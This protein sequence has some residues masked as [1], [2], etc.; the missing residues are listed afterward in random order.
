M[1]DNTTISQDSRKA[2]QALDALQ[3]L[4]SGISNDPKDKANTRDLMKDLHDAIITVQTIL[5][6]ITPV[7]EGVARSELQTEHDAKST[8]QASRFANGP[9]CDSKP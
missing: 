1:T 2:I 6:R 9:S 5:G 3:S 8:A 7:N 4:H